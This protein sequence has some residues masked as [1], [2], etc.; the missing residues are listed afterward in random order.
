[1]IAFGVVSLLLV[2]TLSFATYALVRAWILNDRQSAVVRQAYTDARLVRNHLRSTTSDV[3]A[4]L[5]GLQ[6]THNGGALLTLHGLWYS[7]SVAVERSQV[8]ASLQAVIGRDHAGWQTATSSAGPTVVVGVPIAESSARFYVLEP[9]TDVGHT[10]RVLAG[11][12]AL[13]AG[14]AAIVGAGTGALVSRRILRPLRDV[15]SVAH[16]VAAGE[17]TTRLADNQDPDLGPLV[18]SFNHM[19]DEL[20]ERARREARFAADVSHDLRGPLAAF[21]SAVSVVH[22]RRDTLPPEA[23]AAI[24]I[25]ETQVAAFNFLVVDLL[26]ISRFEAGT[27][28]LDTTETDAVEFVRTVLAETDPEVPVVCPPGYDPRVSID[29]RRLQRVLANLLE[30]ARNY[31]GGASRVE[32]SPAGDGMIAIAVEDHGPGVPADVRHSIFTRYD[33]GRVANDPTTPKGSGLGLALADQHAKLHGG[34][35][36]V[37]DAGGGGAR[38]VIKLPEAT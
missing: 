22:R 32:I 18:V 4:L 35:I 1:M 26:E 15:S 9:M 14:L 24:D 30:N 11:A 12:L 23:C 25:L 21:S 6:F 19:V 7:S 5:S 28:T 2:G 29:R 20:E 3:P 17:G 8:P 37:E 38:F 27:I 13:A 36:H 16:D 33:R 31:G 10:L 34:T